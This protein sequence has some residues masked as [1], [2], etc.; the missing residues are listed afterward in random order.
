MAHYSTSWLY[1]RALTLAH[2]LG[3]AA[4]IDVSGTIPA[5]DEEF[6]TNVQS[7]GQDV[8]I[9]GPDGVTL[10]TFDLASF[11]TTN[12]TG[13]FEID[14]YSVP[15]TNKVSKAWLYYGN[16]GASTGLT[17]F[18]PFSAYNGY[19]ELG[20]PVGRVVVVEP[21]RSG[22]TIPRIDVVK[23]ANEALF[24][25]FDFSRMLENSV[26]PYNGRPEWE[27]I[28]YLDALEVLQNSV[29]QTSLYTTGNHRFVGRGR[30]RA[31]IKAGTTAN[32]YTISCRVATV[33]PGDSSIAR[34]LE[35]RARLRV[36]NTSEA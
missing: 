20:D 5:T 8:R 18:S 4:T 26:I 28:A 31:W 33:R 22:V 1:R 29:D 34:I 23:T 36:R 15:A 27:E 30:V 9:T 10:L 16:S 21:E 24:V 13:T 7:A 12:R 2:S 3:G 35:G 11:D 6:W 19:V 17:T 25:D 14:N 32:D